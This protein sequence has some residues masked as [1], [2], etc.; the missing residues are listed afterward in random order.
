MSSSKHS[1]GTL[2]TEYPFNSI[3]FF[4]AFIDFMYMDYSCNLH[5]YHSLETCES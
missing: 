3:V 5:I 4:N 1:I 2:T